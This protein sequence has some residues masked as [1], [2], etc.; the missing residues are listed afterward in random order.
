MVTPSEGMVYLEPSK[1]LFNSVWNLLHIC[2]NKLWRTLPYVY[3]LTNT[4][5]AAFF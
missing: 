2:A 1:N 5:F 4:S 3:E